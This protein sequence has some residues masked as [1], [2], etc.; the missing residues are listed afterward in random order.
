MRDGAGT[1]APTISGANV[2]ASAVAAVAA[3]AVDAVVG[4]GSA[5]DGAGGGAAE[6]SLGRTHA[7][8]MQRLA[9]EVD[10]AEC[11]P[12]VNSWHTAREVSIEG[13]NRRSVAT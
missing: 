5:R 1:I 9:S 10:A 6:E 4:A 11:I 2:R 8:N 7:L 13:R 3:V 12:I